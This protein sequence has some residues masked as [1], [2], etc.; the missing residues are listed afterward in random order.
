MATYLSRTPASAGNRKIYLWSGWV[1]RSLV[2]GTQQDLM[3][4]SNATNDFGIFYF[5]G[6]ESLTLNLKQIVVHILD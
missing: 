5:D 4:V 3:A 6:D 1:K 2:N